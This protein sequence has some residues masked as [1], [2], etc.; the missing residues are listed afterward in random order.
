[1]IEIW[2]KKSL[3]KWQQLQHCKIYNT[4]E[5]FYKEWQIVL[6]EHLVLVTLYCGLQLAL[7]KTIRIGDTKY[8][9]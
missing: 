2:M 1:M 9:I 4:P 7:S 8:H 5:F 6:G 3:G